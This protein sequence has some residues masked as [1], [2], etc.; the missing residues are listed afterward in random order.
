LHLQFNIKISLKKNLHIILLLIL[1]LAT[2]VAHAQRKK[3]K[4]NKTPGYEDERKIT[5]L[6][7]DA[8]KQ[9][10][11][12][13]YEEAA[14][15]YHDCIKIDPNNAAAYYELGNLILN[16]EQTEDA[17]PFA[18]RAME[19]QP[20]NE[21]YALFAANIHQNLNNFTAAAR[22]YQRLAKQFPAKVEYQYELGSAY[23]F[24]NR[25]ED[26]ISVYDKIEQQIGVSE[27]LSIQKEKIYLQ[28]DKLDEAVKELKN[29]IQN[30]PREQRYLGM[31]A[32]IYIANEQ[33]D[34][35]FEVYKRMLKNDAD[36]PILRLNLAEYYRKK[37]EN[38]RSFDEL[39]S[40]FKSSA[41]NI[42]RKIQVLMSYYALTERDDRLLNQAYKLIDFMTEAHPKDAKAFAMKADFL[43]RDGKLKESR[44][45]F[46]KTVQLDSSRF[47]VWSQLI[48]VSY[49]L[50]DFT[51]MEKD[52]R[53]TLELFPNQG[54]VYLFNGIANNSLKQ[55]KD[56][57]N[58][59][60]EGEIFT[61]TNTY[62]NVQLLSVLGDVYNN[63]EDFENSDKAFEK[64]L[65]KDPNNA[66]ILNNYSYFL[67]LRVENLDRAEELS[68]KSNLL[69]PR[70]ASY[71]DTYGWILFQQKKYTEALEWMTKALE[72]GGAQSGVIVE[73]YADVLYKLGK[74]SEATSEWKKALKL[75]DYSNVLQQK[76]DGTKFP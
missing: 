74:V 30:F 67:S 55:Y 44:Q 73:H 27:D 62:L 66:L 35:A 15:L 8:S 9:K 5:E 20:S 29:L 12:E 36:D 51:A 32:E 4:K 52:S 49:E 33:L 43:L 19:L 48:N 60:E 64:A 17:L 38:D 31:L 16:T 76:I 65:D 70:Q 34:K 59:L 25:L 71:Q 56:A 24:L 3:K 26:A 14:L 10:M 58:V 40:A 39:Q 46:Y 75:G 28:L 61:R 54:S 69:N 72:N 2:S 42:D 23:L 21:W 18:L 7:F 47:P 50:R 13:N 11:L 68:K 22:V 41:L 45:A 37:G 1:V 63:L 57:A 6:F 53:T